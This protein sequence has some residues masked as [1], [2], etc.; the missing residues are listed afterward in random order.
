[1][2]T[3]P[4][5]LLLLVGALCISLSQLSGQAFNPTPI[6]PAMVQAAQNGGV[7]LPQ[8]FQLTNGERCVVFRCQTDNCEDCALI[9]RDL[10]NDGQVNPKTEIRC[11]CKTDA[12][13]VCQLQ[14]QEVN[15]PD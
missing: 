2:M 14:R 1:M 11:R 6:T 10:N 8:P 15:C 13:Q 3:L 12:E 5:S 9:W 7:E 4:K